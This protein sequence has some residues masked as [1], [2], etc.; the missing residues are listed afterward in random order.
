[1]RKQLKKTLNRLG[2]EE[3]IIN[4]GSK[5]ENKELFDFLYKLKESVENDFGA[6]LTWDR[7][8]ENVTLVL[9]ILSYFE[10][11]DLDKMNEFL[12]DAAIRMEN[13]FKEPIRKINAYSKPKSRHGLGIFWNAK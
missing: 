9:S 6:E 5:E 2:L 10:E 8:D 3:I 1:M 4:R 12:I 13:G 7:M 11:D